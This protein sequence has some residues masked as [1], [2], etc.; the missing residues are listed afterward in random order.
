M[1]TGQQNPREALNVLAQSGLIALIK[2]GAAGVI[3][4]RAG[5]LFSC[6]ALPVER[7]V[8]TTGAGDAFD[9]GFIYATLRGY[10]FLD[11]LRCGIICGSLSTTAMTGTAAVPTAA[12]LERIRASLAG[13]HPA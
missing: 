8:D 1:I 10:S 5:E 2:V 13:D 6:P 11:A 3:A 4:L 7:V 12:E 9:A